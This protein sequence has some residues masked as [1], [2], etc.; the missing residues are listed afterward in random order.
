MRTQNTPAAVGAVHS[1]EIEYA[2]GNLKLMSDVYPWTEDDFK[3]SNV[4]Q[5]YFANF[6]KK[7]DPNGSGLPQWPV[8]SSGKVMRLDVE[9]HAEPDSTRARYLFLDQLPR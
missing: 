6:V 5:S 8:V 7:G 4:M 2:M 9:P 1:A 3:V